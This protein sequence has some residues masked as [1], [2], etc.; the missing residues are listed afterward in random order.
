MQL[1]TSGASA[2]HPAAAAKRNAAPAASWVSRYLAGALELLEVV[3]GCIEYSS[4]K[5]PVGRGSW[6]ATLAGSRNNSS[7]HLNSTT[8]FCCRFGRPNAQGF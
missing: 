8:T 5:Q 3:V 4:A 7:S 2:Q 1:K 6:G